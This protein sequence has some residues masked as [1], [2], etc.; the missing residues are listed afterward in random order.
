MRL[1]DYRPRSQLRTASHDVRRPR[2]PA[3]DAHSHLGA[4]FGDGWA[5]RSATELADTLDAA[6]VEAIVNLDGGWGDG[7][8]GAIDRWQRP[9]PGRVAV[10]AT[11][12]YGGWAE[13]RRLR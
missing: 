11:L 10:F 1:T 4:A 13:R 12:D 3:I 2:F 8:R 7:L 9:L 5:S 6:G